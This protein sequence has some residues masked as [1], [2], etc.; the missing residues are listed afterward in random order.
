MQAALIKNAFF[1]A[2]MLASAAL[3]LARQVQAAS[4]ISTSTDGKTYKTSFAITMTLANAS[5]SLTSVK[6]DQQ[7]KLTGTITPDPAHA[8]KPADIF[9]VERM[10]NQLYM[11]TL[12]G[13]FVPWDGYVSKLKPAKEG[14]NLGTSLNVEVYTGTYSNPATHQVFIG[15]MPTGGS[16]L[17]YTPIPAVFE[18]K[19]EEISI[20]PLTYFTDKIEAPLIQTR[21]IACHVGGGVAKDSAMILERSSTTSAQKIG[22]AHV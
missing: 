11:R 10:D 18:I 12:D 13:V 1:V 22:R 5:D 14:V 6:V 8:N 4:L 20:S 21:C 3:P 17:I 2:A 7:V 9:I 16:A 19:G 15:Y